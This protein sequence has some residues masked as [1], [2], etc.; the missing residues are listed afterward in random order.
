MTKGRVVR[1]WLGIMGLEVSPRMAAYHRLPRS[2]GIFITALV[3]QGPAAR[4]GL[5]VGDLL[6]HA[7]GKQVSGMVDL[8]SLMKAREPGDTIELEVIRNGVSVKLR[9]QLDTRPTETG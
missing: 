5:R 9:V 3:K 2:T 4:A 6:V 7:G 8:S 1:P